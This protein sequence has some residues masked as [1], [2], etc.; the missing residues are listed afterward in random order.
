MK[1]F[2]QVAAA[3][4][5][6]L[7]TFAQP[8]MAAESQIKVLVTG[9]ELGADVAPFIEND[10]TLV[11]LRAL[12][13]KLGFQI[14]W[15]EAERKITL[16]REAKVVILWVDKTE[17]LVDG[18]KVTLEVAPKIVS[19]RTFVPL[20]FVSE[21]LGAKVF[22]DGEHRHVRV[23]PTGQS[24]PDALAL[25]N[26]SNAQMT[27]VQMDGDVKLQVAAPGQPSVELTMK[28]VATTYKNEMLNRIDMTAPLLGAGF[29]AM[30]MT[31]AIRGGHMY[32]K[33]E[34]PMAQ[35]APQ[36]WQDLGAIDEM[37]GKL[38]GE[39]S[40]PFGSA[41]PGGATIS[42]EI[43]AKLQAFKD[44]IAVT[45]GQPETVNGRKLVRV[46]MDLSRVNFTDLLNLF[47]GDS[48]EAQMAAA[49][50][51][52]FE[53]QFSFWVDAETKQPAKFGMK[54]HMVMAE[55]GQ[56]VRMD[57]DGLFN[58]KPQ[59]GPIEWPADLPKPAA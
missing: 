34:G 38:G 17:A 29:P 28:M 9:S 10:R 53:M 3:A 23:T 55:D 12:S 4:L 26:G 20:R 43:L 6:A 36:G 31:Q 46:D 14:G 5:L 7:A 16:T 51:K 49:M 56:E 27:D 42:P 8:A 35:G 2:S 24:D 48:A 13:E 59:T 15:D 22:W 30:Q 19:D 45:F 21:Q 11:P 50:F 25:L 57:M 44:G 18:Q 52:E 58:L 37:G 47:A 39:L 41:I 54:V 33:M 1:R 32:M 40:N